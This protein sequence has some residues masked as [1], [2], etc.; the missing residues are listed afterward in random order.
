MVTARQPARPLSAE[1]HVTLARLSASV[2]AALVCLID[3]EAQQR[4]LLLDQRGAP[5]AAQESGTASIDAPQS[6]QT[7]LGIMT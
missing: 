4:A 3:Y 2:E 7:S 5:Q 1:G 6:R